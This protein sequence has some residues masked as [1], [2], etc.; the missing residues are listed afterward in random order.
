MVSWPTIIFPSFHLITDFLLLVSYRTTPCLRPIYRVYL[1]TIERAFRMW[2]GQRFSFLLA[3]HYFHITSILSHIHKNQTLQS[4][5]SIAHHSFSFLSLTS[6]QCSARSLLH[7]QML[8]ASESFLSMARSA[9]NLEWIYVIGCKR[10]LR[11]SRL[12]VHDAPWEQLQTDGF[13]RLL[14]VSID[15]SKPGSGF[16]QA[17]DLLM[18]IWKAFAGHMTCPVCENSWL[19]LAAPYLSLDFS[20]SICR[21]WNCQEVNKNNECYG[22]SQCKCSFSTK[23]KPNK[24]CQRAC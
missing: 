11:A 23:L 19:L 5:S 6:Q 22:R 12:F 7:N 4:P 15:Q 10:K 2:S 21:F 13:A 24:P 1:T 18:A 20:C 8:K 9:G 3:I 16:V 14:P 17:G